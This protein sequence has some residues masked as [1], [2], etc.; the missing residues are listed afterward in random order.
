[1]RPATPDVVAVMSSVWMTTPVVTLTA[2]PVPT[3][4]TVVP[5][6]LLFGA[7]RFQVEGE[8]PP[9]SRRPLSGEPE[10]LTPPVY[11]PVAIATAVRPVELDTV[12]P[13]A[14]V[15]FGAA[16]V[17]PL[18]RLLPLGATNTVFAGS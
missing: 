5:F 7:A 11:A 13:S 4:L 9:S 15:G 14:I 2:T 8:K 17:I 1:M 12:N 18:F 3:P 10:M 16:G 6:P